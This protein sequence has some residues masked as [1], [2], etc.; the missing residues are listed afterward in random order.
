V[1][2]LAA[3]HLLSMPDID[4]AT[5]LH[6]Y[7]YDTGKRCERRV[8]PGEVFEFTDDQA[9]LEWLRDLEAVRDPTQAEVD[10]YNL[11]SGVR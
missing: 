7:N 11:A 6:R 4:P 9:E 3:V 8:L 2:L 5:G 10:A 1:T